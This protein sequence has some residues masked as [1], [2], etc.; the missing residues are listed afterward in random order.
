MFLKFDVPDDGAN[1][2]D[3]F[4]ITQLRLPCS[5]LSTGVL[6]KF[7]ESS[8]VRALFS[9]ATK[10]SRETRGGG[11]IRYDWL[12]REGETRHCRFSLDLWDFH[13]TQ[14][15]PSKNTCLICNNLASTATLR[16][17]HDMRHI[18]LHTTA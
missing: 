18:T 1:E 2:L 14:P 4:N 12:C 8:R 7:E 5:S 9:P 6:C 3:A 15:H 16:G 17:I 11:T 13:A 10:R